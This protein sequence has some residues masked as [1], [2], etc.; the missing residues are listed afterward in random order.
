M[1]L[2]RLINRPHLTAKLEEKVTVALDG[3]L[4]GEFRSKQREV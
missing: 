2:L 3:A 1:S 4:K